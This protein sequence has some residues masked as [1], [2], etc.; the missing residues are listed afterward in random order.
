MGVSLVYLFL[1]NKPWKT[2]DGL[3]SFFSRQSCKFNRACND[4]KH[5]LLI[6]TAQW[7]SLE[8]VWV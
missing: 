1:F 7:V 4:F 5:P 3:I 6:S 8:L 2:K